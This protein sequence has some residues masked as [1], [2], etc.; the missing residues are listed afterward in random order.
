VRIGS[1][2]VSIGTVSAP[3]GVRQPFFA[4]SS[5]AS[6]A[7]PRRFLLCLKPVL[8]YWAPVE[9]KPTYAVGVVGIEYRDELLPRLHAAKAE[10]AEL[11]AEA[12]AV[13]GLWFG[14]PASKVTKKLRVGPAALSALA[15][16]PKAQAPSIETWQQRFAALIA[17]A[18]DA[19][20]G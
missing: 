19:V 17:G 8:D 16:M 12:R 13:A 4:L 15:D 10:V 1:K 5:S 6:I 3:A 14:M 11:L 20:Q 7:M 2:L 9:A 18:G